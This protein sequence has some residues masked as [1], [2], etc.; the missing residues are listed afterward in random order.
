MK[1]PVQNTR[2]FKIFDKNTRNF[3]ISGKKNTKNFIKS[4]VKVTCF[5][6]ISDM[7]AKF[8]VSAKNLKNL[9]SHVNLL[10]CGNKKILEYFGILYLLGVPSLIKTCDTSSS[11]IKYSI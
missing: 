9:A 4:T 11:S 7:H 6:Q 2:Y 3:T 5:R 10:K 8:L 1:F